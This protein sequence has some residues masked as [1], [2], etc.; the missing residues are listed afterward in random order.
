MILNGSFSELTLIQKAKE[1]GFYVV[2][3]GNMPALI[4]HS[5]ADEY[6]PADY[7]DKEQ[8]LSLVKEN[9]IT[10]IVSNANDFGVLTAA[11]VAEQMGW[12]GHDTYEHAVLLHHKD[13]FKAYCIEKGIPSPKSE[14]F[15]DKGAAF[16]YAKN[17]CYPIIVK[18]NDLTGGKGISRAVNFSEAE[19]AIENAFQKSRDKCIVMEPFLTGRQQSFGGFISGGKI[20]AAYSNDCISVVNPY[21]IQAETLPAEQIETIRPELERIMQEIV[22]DLNLCDGIFCL[23]YMVCDGRPYIIEMM[24]RCFGNQFLTLASANTGFPWEEAYL[25]AQTGQDTSG[26]TC[27]EP[28]RKYCGH[29]G[30]MISQNGIFKRYTIAPEFEKHIFMKIDMLKPGEAIEDCMNQRV[31]YV[32]YAYDSG[33]EMRAASRHFHEMVH[34]ELEQ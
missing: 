11:Y 34:V 16:T 18:A 20:I 23:Q 1:M 27:G 14:I 4:G 31:A 3:T 22:S 33:A 10:K 2:T 24:R 17:C 6:I 29:Y 8:I 26:I 25:L 9:R 5:Y 28:E 12:E 19:A 15:T 13:K 7:S 30:I 32:Y 21:L